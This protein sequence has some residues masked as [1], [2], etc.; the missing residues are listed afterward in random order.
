MQGSCFPTKGPLWLPGQLGALVAQ[1][2]GRQL[3]ALCPIPHRVQSSRQGRSPSSLG[4]VQ[5]PGAQSP[6]V[7]VCCFL[8]R[9]LAWYQSDSRASGLD[10]ANRQRSSN[11]AAPTDRGALRGAPHG[12]LSPSQSPGSQPA[13]AAPPPP[14]G[15]RWV[16][17]LGSVHIL[18]LQGPFLLPSTC[19]LLLAPNPSSGSST[20]GFPCYSPECHH[21]VQP[22]L[23]SS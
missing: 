19:H 21:R 8:A 11:A 2:Q 17:G 5:T 18:C 10:R 4:L 1:T 12:A 20:S 7:P 22:N 14:A 23:G 6:R 3:W 16:V 15:V 9:V 13:A